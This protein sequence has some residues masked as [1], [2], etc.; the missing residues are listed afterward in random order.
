MIPLVEGW[1]TAAVRTQGR[2][3]TPSKRKAKNEEK[4][5]HKKRKERKRK[6]REKRQWGKL[7]WCC[8]RS[9]KRAANDG[10]VQ[11][12]YQLQHDL[13]ILRGKGGEEK[14]LQTETNR[15]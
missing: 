6:E 8:T 7:I 1:C 2:D 4:E 10:W 5:I 15:D 13:K 11:P 3:R 14:E 12:S 9:F